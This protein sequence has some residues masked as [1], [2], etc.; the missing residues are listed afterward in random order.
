MSDAESMVKLLT[1]KNN[2]EAKIIAALLETAGIPTHVPG[3]SLQDEFAMVQNMMGVGAVDVM[4]PP[5]ALEDAR[6]V[7]ADARD[8]G[9]LGVSNGNPSTDS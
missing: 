4:V 6:R 3:Q 7:V 8:A 9:Q 5:D 2:I 1:A